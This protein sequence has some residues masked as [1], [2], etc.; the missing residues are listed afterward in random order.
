MR[1][2]HTRMPGHV[3]HGECRATN[4]TRVAAT[5][6]FT[7]VVSISVHYA[8]FTRSGVA[9]MRVRSSLSGVSAGSWDVE[10]LFV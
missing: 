1:S 5:R 2:P 7:S 10:P 9:K 6:S 3:D 4:P 8:R